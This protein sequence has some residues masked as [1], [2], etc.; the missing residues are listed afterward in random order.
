MALGDVPRLMRLCHHERD[1]DL[2]RCIGQLAQDLEFRIL[3]QRH[4][5]ED[6][7]LDRTDVLMD[8]PVLIHHEYIFSFKDLLYRKS[9]SDFDRQLYYSPV[10]AR[11]SS[12]VI[13]GI[14]SSFAFLFLPDV[15]AASLLIR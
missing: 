12:S 8:R 4:E 10:M 5:V 3:L 11:N 6:H 15:L 9:V 14:P 7:D 2:Q 13:T 1:V